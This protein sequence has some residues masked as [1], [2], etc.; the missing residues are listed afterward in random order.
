MF[1]S[2]NLFRHLFVELV[3]VFLDSTR[4]VFISV[5]VQEHNMFGTAIRYFAK[6]SK[7]KMKT[8]SLKTPPEQRQTITRALFD[9]V[10]EH[11]PLTIG[12]TWQRIQV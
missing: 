4:K 10:N 1:Y 6:K 12:E 9:I 3:L 8:V 11:G 2:W 5:S 7:P